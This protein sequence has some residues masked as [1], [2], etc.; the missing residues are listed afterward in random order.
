MRY[1][2]TS[3]SILVLID[4]IIAVM[5]K[6]MGS[7]G[8]VW[9]TMTD[10]R[11]HDSAPVIKAYSR[12]DEVFHAFFFGPD[13]FKEGNG[14]VWGMMSG[15]KLSPLRLRF[16]CECLQSVDSALRETKADRG[17]QVVRSSARDALPQLT[18]ELGVKTVYCHSAYGTDEDTVLDATTERLR[19]IGV[20]VDVSAGGA[21]LTEAPHDKL[22]LASF[23]EFRKAVEVRADC[24]AHLPADSYALLTTT[25]THAAPV[26][27]LD[28]DTL[29]RRLSKEIVAHTDDTDAEGSGFAAYVADEAWHLPE[30]DSRAA[31]QFVGGTAAA[32]ARTQHYC[33]LDLAVAHGRS[34]R[35]G[36]YKRRRNGMMGNEYSTKLR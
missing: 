26:E 32:V 33:D 19:E 5:S 29:F 14:G 30:Q 8:L 1:H 25:T 23:S 6:T 28:A 27:P 17:L 9:H 4:I 24:Y 20:S 22:P 35:L 15:V 16:L 10:L 12:C 2:S 18:K 21:F 11:I 7:K 13:V 34:G 3:Y 31:L 36:A